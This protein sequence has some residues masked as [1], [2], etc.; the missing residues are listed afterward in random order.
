MIQATN[1]QATTPRVLVVDDERGIRELLGDILGN[2]GFEVIQ[3]SSG[4]AGLTQAWR[5]SPDVVLLD[6]IMPNMDGFEVLKRADGPQRGPVEVRLGRWDSPT[7]RGAHRRNY[8]AARIG[9]CP[10]HQA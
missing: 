10:M 1:T 9:L 7:D 6:V 4:T 2:A 5:E 8:R 3:A